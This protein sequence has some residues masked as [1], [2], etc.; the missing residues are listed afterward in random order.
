MAPFPR[1]QGFQRVQ[2]TR[3]SLR[4]PEL[5]AERSRNPFHSGRILTNV[6]RVRAGMPDDGTPTPTPSL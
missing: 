5:A 1:R 3:G 2:G 4:L 6:P